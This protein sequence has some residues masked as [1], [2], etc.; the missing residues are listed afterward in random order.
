[1]SYSSP[2][3]LALT[4]LGALANARLFLLPKRIIW[5]AVLLTD[6]AYFGYAYLVK[7]G[8]AACPATFV[9]ALAVACAAEGLARVLKAP[10]QCLSVPAILPLA[11]GLYLCRAI[12]AWM[13]ADYA[14]GY[15]RFIEASQVAL[16]IAL[17]LLVASALVRMQGRAHEPNE[18]RSPASLSAGQAGPAS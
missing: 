6:L 9:A 10:T 17:A 11:P 8:V 2:Q 16:S 18:G 12:Y 14:L 15:Q 7:R 1:M 5:T 3:L 4:T 13:D